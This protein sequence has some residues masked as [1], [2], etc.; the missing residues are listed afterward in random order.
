M[1]LLPYSSGGEPEQNGGIVFTLPR[2]TAVSDRGLVINRA[3]RWNPRKVACKWLDSG[4]TERTSDHVV[5]YCRCA[6]S[7][8]AAISEVVSH[9]V[10][11]A[12]G[13]RT[14][15]PAIVV[16]EPELSL[17]YAA[18]SDVDYAIEPGEH[19]GTQYVGFLSSEKW[20]LANEDLARPEHLIRIWVADCWLMNIDR[21]TYGNVIMEVTDTGKFHIIPAD[22]GDNFGGSTRLMSGE[23]INSSKGDQMVSF[24]P[25]LQEYVLQ[26]G[27][28]G[29]SDSVRAV[30][31][32]AYLLPSIAAQVPAAWWL[33]SGVNSLDLVKC[34]QERANRIRSIINLAYWEGLQN[35]TTGGTI[36]DL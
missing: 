6:T 19:F 24:M 18:S 25:G 17:S 7:A 2:V 31:E 33:R 5:K 35:A 12:M 23:Y 34:M 10:Y 30:L 16:V 28:R 32:A 4:G 13:C 21:L 8:A 14:L 27:T 3:T 15:T 9:G 1:T 20:S 11:R 29:F 36:L 26:H 22:N